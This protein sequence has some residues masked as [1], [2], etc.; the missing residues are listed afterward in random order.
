MY[1]ETLYQEGGNI[2]E[3]VLRV[4]ML[5][6]DHIGIR[7]PLTAGD[8]Q[9]RVEGH[10]IKEDIWIESLQGGDILIGMEDPLEK[11]DTQKEDPLMEMEDP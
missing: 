1:R 5:I 11:E 7:D 10:L 4:I 9:I 3:K 8:T 2:Q 6:E